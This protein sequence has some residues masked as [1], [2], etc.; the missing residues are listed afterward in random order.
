MGVR[1]WTETERG[2][3][4]C[5]YM[6]TTS[7]SPYLLS[8]V[9]FNWHMCIVKRHTYLW[10]ADK[11]PNTNTDFFLDTKVSWLQ[12]FWTQCKEHWNAHYMKKTW[13]NCLFHCVSPWQSWASPWTY[14]EERAP[15]SSCKFNS[16]TIRRFMTN[17]FVVVL[18][19][20]NSHP[21]SMQH[22]NS[23]YEDFKQSSKHWTSNKSSARTS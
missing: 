9:C 2:Q 18:N 14:N 10:G 7:V 3:C 21:S 15:E 4:A 22:Y 16:D 6:C 11:Q 19:I 17:L 1:V 8:S 23:K 5:Q 12:W 20:F 13:D